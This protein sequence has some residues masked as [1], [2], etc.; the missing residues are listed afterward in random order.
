MKTLEDL[1]REVAKR[2]IKHRSAQKRRYELSRELGFSSQEAIV[3]Q[4]W[5]EEDIRRLAQDKQLNHQI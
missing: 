3:L 1:K 2:Q 4:N 5:K